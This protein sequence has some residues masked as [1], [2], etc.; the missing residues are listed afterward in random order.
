MVSGGCPNDYIPVGGCLATQLE[1]WGV[2][3]DYKATPTKFLPGQLWQM[4]PPSMVIGQ[5]AITCIYYGFV[6]LARCMEHL[7]NSQHIPYIQGSR[8]QRRWAGVPRCQR[9]GRWKTTRK[10]A[11]STLMD[12][13][14][15]QTGW[16]RVCRWLASSRSKEI[17]LNSLFI[18]LLRLD[19]NF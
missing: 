7:N 10:T 5:L 13:L 19:L 3:W 12:G 6:G 11:E 16:R 4:S 17:S 1:S 18:S 2:K 14:L 9:R 15:T 8:L